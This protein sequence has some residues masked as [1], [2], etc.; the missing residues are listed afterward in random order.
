MQCTRRADQS[1]HFQRLTQ[2]EIQHQAAPYEAIQGGTS[3]YKVEKNLLKRALIA[4][5]GRFRERRAE[6]R[7]HEKRKRTRKRAIRI[8]AHSFFL[9][10][11][12]FRDQIRPASA[13]WRGAACGGIDG[14][15]AS[16]KV[17]VPFMNPLPFRISLLLLG[18]AIF[19]LAAQT[20]P[21]RAE[22]VARFRSGACG[23]ISLPRCPRW[24]LAR[25]CARRRMGRF[26]W[27]TTCATNG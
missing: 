18:A 8:A 6:G 14:A 25:R 10:F 23:S 27:A 22:A 1:K 2:P 20:P 21:A 5:V 7:I 11:R 26:M 19:P 9:F 17:N 4:N 12:V 24:R 16:F 13:A 15:V 3:P